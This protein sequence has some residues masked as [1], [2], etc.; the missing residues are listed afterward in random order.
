MPE[1]NAWHLRRAVHILRAG[2]V[3]AY[4]TEA[5]YG[6]GCDPFNERAI[7]RLL[8]IKDR[9]A[10]KGLI[11]IA[12]DP[13]QL[14]ALVLPQSSE[15]MEPVLASWPG[16]ITWLLPATPAVPVWLTGA[17][18]RIA[19]RV[20]AHP[21]AAALCRG[22]GG[23]LVS[24]SANRSGRPPARTALQARR[25]LGDRVDCFITGPTGGAMRPSEI[26]DARDG[27]VLRAG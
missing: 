26:R 22:F 20:T 23:A 16:P 11:V 27:R 6:L 15:T 1:L 7:L 13:E 4:P 5:V 8:A 21:L 10:D 9:A 17:S 12:A 3:V 2:G 25:M 14:T 24:T 19:V 18:E